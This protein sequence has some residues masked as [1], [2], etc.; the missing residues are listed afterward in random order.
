MKSHDKLLIPQQL[1]KMKFID[2]KSGVSIL[3]LRLKIKT[4]VRFEIDSTQ[5]RKFVKRMTNEKSLDFS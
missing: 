4:N 5:A 1:S 2:V 3:I